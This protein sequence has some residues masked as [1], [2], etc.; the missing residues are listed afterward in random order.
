M[1][2]KMHTRRTLISRKTRSGHPLAIAVKPLSVIRWHPHKFNF[3]RGQFSAIADSPASDTLKK[4]NLKIHN[5]KQRGQYRLEY[6]VK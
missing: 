2:E 3:C 5:S 1:I 6:Q 4:K